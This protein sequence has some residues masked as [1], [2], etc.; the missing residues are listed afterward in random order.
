MLGSRLRRWRRNPL[1]A[2]HHL[3]T[4]TLGMAAV[5]AVVSL[6]LA[7]AFQP[8]PFRDSARLVEVW[9]RVESGA[10]VAALSGAELVELQEG[11]GDIFAYLGGFNQVRWWLLDEPGSAEP[12]GV[13][14]LDEA[15]FRALDLAPV[16]GRPV[17]G[18]TSAAAGIAPVWISHRLWQSRYGGR[19]SVV[20]ETIRVAQNDAGLYETRFEVAGVLPP[21]IRIPHPAVDEPV[22]LW[23]ILP[24]ATKVRA[25]KAS[26][27]FALG[28]LQPGRTLAEAQAAVT[29]PGRPPAAIRRIGVTV[30]SFKVS[31]TLLEVRHAARL[32]YWRLVSAWCSCSP[33]PISPA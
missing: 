24:E 7:V 10:P 32:A 29:R 13:A 8:L 30:L 1:L 15:A 17:R 16:L 18:S 22:D 3:A 27:F 31:R 5:T 20:G 6:M 28:R 23:G 26:V 4:M 11:T 33:L 25:A 19:S 12:L 2:A 9:N 21:D 14:R